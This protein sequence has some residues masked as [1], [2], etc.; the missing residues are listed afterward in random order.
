MYFEIIGKI[1]EI[2]TI[3]IGNKIREIESL[4]ENGRSQALA[5]AHTVSFTIHLHE[6][7]RNVELYWCEAHGIGKKKMKIKRYID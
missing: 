1:T 5:R 3:A 6:P 2:E 4:R 7:L